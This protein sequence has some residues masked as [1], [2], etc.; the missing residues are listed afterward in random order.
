MFKLEEM[1]LKGDRKDWSGDL[2]IDSYTGAEIKT[3][4]KDAKEALSWGKEPEGGMEMVRLILELGNAFND[5]CRYRLYLVP[6]NPKGKGYGAIKSEMVHSPSIDEFQ[7]KINVSSVWEDRNRL[8]RYTGK[9]IKELVN[10]ILS[11]DT[12]YWYGLLDRDDFEIFRDSYITG[13]FP[14]ADNKLYWLSY[15]G[16]RGN[17]IICRK[18]EN[19]V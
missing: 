11:E 17:T 18:W 15:G 5:G 19:Q 8:R 10:R 3:A 9:E 2:T 12:V 16:Y 14:I 4:L 13:E 1:I 7:S 6:P